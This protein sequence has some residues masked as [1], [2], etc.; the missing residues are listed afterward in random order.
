MKMENETAPEQQGTHNGI[1]QIRRRVYV[2]NHCTST[3]CRFLRKQYFT[4]TKIYIMTVSFS[5]FPKWINGVSFLPYVNLISYLIRGCIRKW[6]FPNDCQV[7]NSDPTEEKL[8][9]LYLQL[10]YPIS[11][12][13]CCCHLKAC[14]ISHWLKIN[15]S[16]VRSLQ[17]LKCTNFSNNLCKYTFNSIWT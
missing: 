11:L 14:S 5:F 1:R 7:L 13:K 6:C 16:L 15:A 8:I 12:I 17:L 10:T 9:N 4:S 2:L 3:D